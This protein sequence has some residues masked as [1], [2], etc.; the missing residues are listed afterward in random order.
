MTELVA[1]DLPGGEASYGRSTR[2]WARRTE[3]VLVVDQ[4]LP[5][6][7]AGPC[8]LPPDH[9]WRSI[10]RRGVPP[11]EHPGPELESGDALVAAT[12]GSSGAP[13]AGGPHPRRLLAHA[14]AV[15]RHLEVDPAGPVA[16]LPAADHLGGF[17]VVARSVLTGT[18][19]RVLP[20]FDPERVAEPRRRTSGA[21]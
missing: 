1:L 12:S 20:G 4:R 15:H 2:A 11:P 19:C 18:P 8:S 5:P 16:G 6:P 14:E 13:E 10:G 3:A 9:T 17:G 7:A 21:R